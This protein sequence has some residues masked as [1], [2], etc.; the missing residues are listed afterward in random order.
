MADRAKRLAKLEELKRARLGES[1]RSKD[2]KVSGKQACV[3]TTQSRRLA[4][5][6][7]LDK[8]IMYVKSTCW[9]SIHR[10]VLLGGTLV[11]D[12]RQSH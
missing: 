2:Y 11:Q 6:L 3:Q 12:I 8:D 5:H 1:N 10:C 9:L 4:G 7:E